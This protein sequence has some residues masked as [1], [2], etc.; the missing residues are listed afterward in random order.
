MTHFQTSWQVE[1][2]IAA[3]LYQPISEL[4]IET[5]AELWYEPGSVSLTEVGNGIKINHKFNSDLYVGKKLNVLG[6]GSGKIG[7]KM[8]MMNVKMGKAKHLIHF[9]RMHGFKWH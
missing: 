7:G 5:T 4:Y 8:M 2:Q 1:T 9:L 3:S 6:L